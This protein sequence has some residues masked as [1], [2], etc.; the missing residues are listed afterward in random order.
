MFGSCGIS[1][2][3]WSLVG[4]GELVGVQVGNGL[5]DKVGAWDGAGDRDTTFRRATTFV[6]VVHWPPPPP[7]LHVAP[8]DLRFE[9]HVRPIF[10]MPKMCMS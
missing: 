1:P 6:N 9:A 5:G 3:V 7:A 10:S 8:A 2:S 4:T